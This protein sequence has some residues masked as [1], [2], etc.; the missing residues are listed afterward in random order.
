MTTRTP[1]PRFDTT[2]ADAALIGKVVVRAM[3]KTD[4]DR[5]EL[6]MDLTACHSNGTP[7]DLARLLQAD[8]FNFLHDIYGI[9]RHI[10][11]STGQLNNHFRPR[12]A[13][14]DNA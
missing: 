7:L 11:R 9:N 2:S 5:L 4:I 10:D 14:H 1:T 8:E 13:Q 6:A 12:F 3:S